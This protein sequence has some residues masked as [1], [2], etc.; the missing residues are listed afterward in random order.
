MADTSF[1]YAE[2][3]IADLQSIWAEEPAVLDTVEVFIAARGLREA[4]ATF[5]RFQHVWI[6]DPAGVFAKLRRQGLCDKSV[7]PL[8]AVPELLE[9]LSN[10][11]R[12]S[13]QRHS[14]IVVQQVIETPA[15]DFAAR[16]G[17]GARRVREFVELQASLVIWLEASGACIPHRPTQLPALPG[18]RPPQSQQAASDPGPPLPTTLGAI[19]AELAELGARSQWARTQI[20]RNVAVW[21]SWRGLGHEG[22]CTLDQIGRTWGLTRERVRQIIQRVEGRAG[23]ALL[24]RLRYQPVRDAVRAVAGRCLGMATA[25]DYAELLKAELGLTEDP[26]TAELAALGS[27]LEGD[28]LE[29]RVVSVG[30]VTVVR[31]AVCCKS[32]KSLCAA[33]LQEAV[34]RLTGT[35]HLA[36]FA[37]MFQLRDANCGGVRD[38]HSRAVVPCCVDVPRLP[39]E[40]VRVQLLELK[41][42]PLEGDEVYSAAWATLRQATRMPDAIEAA[43][44]I[45]GRPAHFTEIADMVRQSSS[46]FE[47][48]STRNMQAC[49]TRERRFVNVEARGTYGLAAWGLEP[50]KPVSDRL[51]ECLERIGCPTRIHQLIAELNDPMCSE[52]NVRA[53]ITQNPKR[54]VLQ[55]GGLVSLAEWAEARSESKPDPERS[56]FVFDDDDDFAI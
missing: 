9:G 29:F 41:P 35:T 12:N 56:L 33:N 52:G 36:D 37:H 30:G 7:A 39:V 4:E 53:A 49:L 17:V 45:L 50:Y 3:V 14:F 34:E 18:V 48:T 44:R 10:P 21:A 42:C 47:N 46:R 6:A 1:D 20:E 26:S 51:A 23:T 38:A 43:L 40:Y 27:L 24:S 5:F 19:L 16:P 11:L 28:R 8:E 32:L 31:H 22:R 54:F 15:A 2:S 25:E 13:L 55:S